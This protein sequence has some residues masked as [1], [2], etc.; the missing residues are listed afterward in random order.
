MSRAEILFSGRFF[1]EKPN[2][3]EQRNT[4][5]RRWFIHS[6][7]TQWKAVVSALQGAAALLS[8]RWVTVEKS[9]ASK[10]S[11]ATSRGE[12][13][14]R[15]LMNAG[16][17]ILCYVFNEKQL[18]NAPPM[19]TTAPERFQIKSFVLVQWTRTNGRHLITAFTVADFQVAYWFSHKTQN[20]M[21]AVFSQHSCFFCF[22]FVFL[23]FTTILDCTWNVW[24]IGNNN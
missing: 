24:G 22:L 9:K 12:G 2:R 19:K 13:H 4:C 16:G 17:A 5:T 20:L 8:C 14:I 21:T 11:W 7:W 6:L 1:Q 3:G 23:A 10:V 18:C 15:V